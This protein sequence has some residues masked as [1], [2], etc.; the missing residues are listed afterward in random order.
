MPIRMNSKNGKIEI[1]G[2]II[3]EQVDTDLF[4][5]ELFSTKSSESDKKKSKPN[6]PQRPLDQTWIVEYPFLAYKSF[7]PDNR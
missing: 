7:M 3:Y 5:L 1:I 2:S 6:Y 4:L